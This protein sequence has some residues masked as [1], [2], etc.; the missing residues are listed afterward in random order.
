MKKYNLYN[1]LFYFAYT[2]MV[3]YHAFSKVI[4]LEKIRNYIIWIAI[5]IMFFAFIIQ[6]RKYVLKTLIKILAVI[7]SFF[8]SSYIAGD[9][10]LFTTVFFI[11][12][13]KNIDFNKF[14]KFDVY[15]KIIVVGCVILLYKLGMTEIIIKIR[16][17]GTIRNSLGFG[18]PNILGAF[19]FSICI[20]IVYLNYKSYKIKHYFILI[21]SLLTCV[22]ICDSRATQIGIGMLIIYTV[23]PKIENKNFYKILPML[24]VFLAVFSFLCSIMY[25]NNMEFWVILNKIS[26]SRIK[27]AYDFYKFYGINLFGHL[28]SFYGQWDKLYSLTVMDNAYMHVLIQYGLINFIIIISALV[29]AIRKMI[30]ENNY[31]LVLCLSTILL[32]GLME[33]YVYQIVYT[34][35]LLYV[36]KILYGKDVEKKNEKENCNNNFSCII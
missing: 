29:I 34:P 20:D 33:S 32:Y 12:T 26:S 9:I 16:E 13:S 3:I 10:I 36:A 30:K 22:Y 31:Q 4:F 25:N 21:L 28:L 8:Y 24:P 6:S 23:L 5:G 11:I 27:C 18:H 14:I 7:S 19:L 17:N 35:I 15:L 1:L 2:L